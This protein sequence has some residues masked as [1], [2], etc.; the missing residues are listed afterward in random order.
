MIH[1]HLQRAL[2]IGTRLG[3]L[4]AIQRVGTALLDRHPA[5]I[6]LLDEHKSVVYANRG[7]EAFGSEMDGVRLSREGILLARKH[8]N[9]KLQ[10]LIAG[11]LSVAAP[12]GTCGGV[13]RALRPSGKRAYGILVAPIAS[14][15]PAL[16]TFRPAVCIVIT[17][18]EA[19][20]SLPLDRLRGGFGLT[21]AEAM[22]AAV[23][24]NGEDLRSAAAR[25]GIT[26]GTA[27][28][29]LSEIFQKTE[30]RRQSELVRVLL[31]T[32]AMP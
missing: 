9:D 28:A 1:S 5:A 32:L 29:R 2:A 26:Y 23:L 10:A 14:R 17:D 31:T 6:L 25:L 11:V 8:D 19:R 30:T 3:S 7:A 21:E 16:M 18:P 22:L 13:M 15:Y 4:G 20:A 12:P 24:A 27:R